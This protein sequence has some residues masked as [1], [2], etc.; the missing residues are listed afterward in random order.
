MTYC[1]HSEV[2]AVHFVKFHRKAT[3]VFTHTHTHTHTLV[4]NAR[5]TPTQHFSLRSQQLQ[6]LK[7]LEACSSNVLGFHRQT[8]NVAQAHKNRSH[9]AR[10]EGRV[11]NSVAPR[12]PNHQPGSGCQTL[13]GEHTRNFMVN[14]Y[15]SC[16]P[17]HHLKLTHY[18][19][20]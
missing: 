11:G 17:C 20:I 14:G 12:R 18:H 10:S 15:F 19:F 13:S 3:S 2:H 5:K 4:Q 1:C 6:P 7:Y 16:G 9:T 8:S